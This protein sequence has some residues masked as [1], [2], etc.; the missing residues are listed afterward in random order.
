MEDL[1]KVHYHNLT[2]GNHKVKS[3]DWGCFLEYQSVKGNL[4]K[5]KCLS[6][7]KIVQTSLIKD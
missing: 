1:L 6:S 5:N 3:K 7:N 4:I 2:E